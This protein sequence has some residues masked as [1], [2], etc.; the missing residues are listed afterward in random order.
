MS[1]SVSCPHCLVPFSS[2]AG[3][4]SLEI[5][6]DILATNRPPLEPEIL[7]IRSVIAEERA[8]KTRLDAQIAALEATLNKF[9]EDRH[10]LEAEI[11]GYEGT[12]SPLRR[13]PPELLSLIFTLARRPS[14]DPAPWTVSQ[15][16]RR[17]REI[18][19]Y[20]PSF[21]ASVV[22]DLGTDRIVTPFRLE[23]HLQR[24]GNL[25]LKVSIISRF[26]NQHT[27]Q[28][29]GLLNIIANYCAR[30]ETVEI[31]G[32]PSLYLL[33]AGVRGYLPI[34]RS[35]DV[36]L[37]L[38]DGDAVPALDA[39]ELAPNLY[40]ATVNTGGRAATVM[41]P[42]PQLQGYVASS[43]WDS[44]LDV[45]ASASNLVE[46]ALQVHDI[47]TP[48]TTKIVLPHLLRLS[49]SKSNLL[50]CLDT[51]KLQ[52]LYC[53]SQSDHLSSLFSRRPYRLQKLVLFYPA[54]VADVTGILRA[55]PT[56]TELGLSISATDIDALSAL[57]TIRNE[58]TDV[59]RD[60]SSIAVC[61]QESGGHM[62]LFGVGNGNLLNLLMGMVESRWRSGRLRSITIPEAY[63]LVR[64]KRLKL[65]KTEGLD[66][67]IAS[68]WDRY[69]L[70]MIPP[71]LCLNDINHS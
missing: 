32:R 58:P 55:S 40:R 47:H 37:D 13:M 35:L 70:D 22:L 15:V 53:S 27:P 5:P 43:S 25:P 28:S 17:W 69:H 52:E 1:S 48:P 21:W 61:F 38:F 9:T 16:C 29:V 66:A 44:H 14:G 12:L 71:H 46:C 65:F 63:G 62:N 39:F 60:L 8:R 18:A 3:P 24:S 42:F 26:K 49:I 64:D 19:I 54:S 33:L 11:L 2:L 50:E 7:R 41:L 10:V 20:Q 51:P 59:G 36:M 30:W 56:L 31:W 67:K 23:A 6:G 34:L 4:Q 45:L 68:S 57:L